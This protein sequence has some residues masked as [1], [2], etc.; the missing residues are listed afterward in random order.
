MAAF[1]VTDMEPTDME[2]TDWLFSLG[3]EYVWSGRQTLKTTNVL[4][5]FTKELGI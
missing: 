4:W 5:D 3:C 1:I 2:P